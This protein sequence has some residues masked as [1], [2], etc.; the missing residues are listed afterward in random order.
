MWK[1]KGKGFFLRIPK[2]ISRF[3]SEAKTDEGEKEEKRS[4]NFS[5]SSYLS[6]SPFFSPP[7]R[8]RFLRRFPFSSFPPPILG[9]RKRGWEIQVCAWKEQKEPLFPDLKKFFLLRKI[10]LYYGHLLLLLRPRKLSIVRGH[11]PLPPSSMHNASKK[12]LLL[13]LMCGLGLGSHKNGWM[14]QKK[15]A[16]LKWARPT[17]YIDHHH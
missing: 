11:F 1:T 2:A 12:A 17:P 14:A 6:F 9:F 5:S 10:L 7:P 16:S 4:K 13:L 15:K 8:F 3:I